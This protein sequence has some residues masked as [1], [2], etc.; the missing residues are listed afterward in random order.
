MDRRMFLRQASA[1]AAG[2]AATT[3]CAA[4]A[5]TEW[6][7]LF[8]GKS[9]DGWETEGDARWRV[10]DGCII[11][12]QGPDGAA[13]DL[14]TEKA[15]DDFQLRVVMR[16]EWPANTGIWFRYQ[17][18][19]QAYQADVLEYEEPLTYSGA[20]Y[21][22]GKMFLAVNED[23]G[24]V[25]KDDWNKFVIRA[26]G[27]HITIRLNGEVTAN[28]HDATSDSGKIGFQI[29]AGDAFNDMKIHVRETH[30]RPIAG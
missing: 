20:L 19:G 23:P 14:L 17:S 9:L 13:G 26:E 12:E 28:V 2:L 24:I 21:C 22:T 6:I 4:E 10:E 16:V 18:A 15:Y 11:G 7:P 1:I 29:H 30:I 25:R 5:K 3:A 8:N 27:D